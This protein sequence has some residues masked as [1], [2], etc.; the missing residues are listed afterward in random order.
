MSTRKDKF[1]KQDSY[2]M[3]LAINLAKNQSGLT[4]AN[5]S[6][7]C[8]IV[9]DNEIISYAATNNGGRPHAETTALNMNIGKNIGSTVYLTMEPC[10]HYGKTPPCTNALIKSKVKKVIYSIEDKDIRC[11]NKS[12]KMY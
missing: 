6:V 5:P 8:V 1:S 2:F 12:K 7:G 10:S 3:K 11:F 4:G 9:K